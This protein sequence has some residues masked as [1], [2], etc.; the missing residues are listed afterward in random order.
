MPAPVSAASSDPPWKGGV[1]FG[2]N[3]LV[4]ARRGYDTEQN[5]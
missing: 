2:S 4:T 5:Q 3:R 1:R